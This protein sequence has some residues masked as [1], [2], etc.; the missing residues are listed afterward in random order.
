[1]PALTIVVAGPKGGCGKTTTAA[2]LI[3]SARLA[4]IEAIGLDLDPQ[5]SLMMWS[6]DRARLGHEPQVRVVA[7]H[8][9]SQ[10][11]SVLNTGGS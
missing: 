9:R 5:G 1:M 3:V 10:G 6:R 7:G 4:S 11:C 8:L 2:N